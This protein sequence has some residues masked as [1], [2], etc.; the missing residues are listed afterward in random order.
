MQNAELEILEDFVRNNEELDQLEALAEVFNTFE[1]LGIVRRELRHSDFLAYLLDPQEN[2][3][4]GDAFVKGLLK[5]ACPRKPV[6]ESTIS[7]IEL[8]TMDF[9]Y[10]E[11]KREWKNI[12]ILVKVDQRLVVIIENKVDTS[13]HSD[14]LQRYH[15]QAVRECVGWKTLC[16][17]LSIYGELPT[18]DSFVP[19]DYGSL[20][21]TLESV[22]KNP[23]VSPSPEARGLI[24]QYCQTV[25]RHFM[26]ESDI[27]T[28]CEQIYKKHKRALDLIFE[29][30]PDDQSRVAGILVDLIRKDNGLVLDSPTKVYV[31]FACKDWD[32]PDLLSGNGWTSSGRVLLFEFRNQKDLLRLNL[33]I[34]PGQ[35]EARQKLFSMALSDEKI[36]KPA[37]KTLKGKWNSIFSRNFLSSND[38]EDTQE[39]QLEQKIKLKW[40]DFIG[41]ELPPIMEAVRNLHFSK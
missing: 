15:E 21:E 4:L 40:K 37:S 23:I 28:L 33:W 20:V 34:G 29:H 11:V 14:Q 25:R 17:Y 16:I 3:G 8:D 1:V 13:E 26:A 27:S 6:D 41:K 12:D 38:Y 30:R 5:R 2:H 18:D 39:N 19:I 31:R 35:E 22:L 7:A 36:F 10:L 9:D 24:S 32:V